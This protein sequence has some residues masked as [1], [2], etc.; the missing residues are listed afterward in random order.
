MGAK[1]YSSVQSGPEFHPT[2]CTIEEEITLLHKL[3]GEKI[4]AGFYLGRE[5]L[6]L[7]LPVDTCVLQYSFL[8]QV[9]KQTQFCQR[10]PTTEI[11]LKR[12]M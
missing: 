7:N 3:I 6:I 9:S 11:P 8:V 1:F 10:Y 4:L 5:H 12:E 2:S